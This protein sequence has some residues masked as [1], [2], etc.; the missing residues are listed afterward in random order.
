[1][2]T[3]LEQLENIDEDEKRLNVKY[4]FF[5]VIEPKLAK[6]ED[7]SWKIGIVI[8]IIAVT[9][10][11]S[12]TSES[13][14]SWR[15]LS[16]IIFYSFLPGFFMAM[17]AQIFVEAFLEYLIFRPYKL[18]KNTYRII[19]NEAYQL[20]R[21][22]SDLETQ[23]RIE[24]NKA[25]ESVFQFKLNDAVYKIENRKISFEEALLLKNELEEENKF[26]IRGGYYYYTKVYYNNRFVKIN[27]AIKNYNEP[28]ISTPKSTDTK[29]SGTTRKIT[30]TSSIPTTIPIEPPVVPEKKVEPFSLTYKPIITTNIPV[31]KTEALI[32]DKTIVTTEPLVVVDKP[33]VKA[34]PSVIKENA[35]K[36]AETPMEELYSNTKSLIKVQR[37]KQ[38]NESLKVD[39]KKLFEK[40]QH[41]G[42]VGEIFAFEWEKRRLLRNGLSLD[43]LMHVSIT[44]DTL[45]YDIVSVNDDGTTRFIE[46]KTTTG[47]SDAPFF[48]SESEKIAMEKL[49]NYSIYRLYSFDIEKGTSGITIID[50]EKGFD[51]YFNFQ[52]IS[53]RVSPK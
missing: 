31:A 25:K 18:N 44:N 17:I 47:S 8:I 45:R 50:K 24:K 22:K 13:F 34:E 19:K 53:Y 15:T 20:N 37:D 51:R 35:G 6:V 30:S 26:F 2:S 16:G 41:I 52:P 9:I 28:I 42:S 49:D 40:K 29:I 7:R 48:M 46:V 32:P 12:F 11:F 21:K 33:V 5:N 27:D 39:Y 1:M 38:Y 3:L 23:I 10:F 14:F 4:P 36:T 43:K